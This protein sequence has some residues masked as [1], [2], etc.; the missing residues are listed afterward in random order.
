MV[1]YAFHQLQTI[2]ANQAK[3]VA[4]RVKTDSRD[5][6]GRWSFPFAPANRLGESVAWLR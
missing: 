4:T 3:V 5:S 2:N 1:Y 6:R